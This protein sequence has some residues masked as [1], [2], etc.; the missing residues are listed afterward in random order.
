MKRLSSEEIEVA[1]TMR[2]NRVSWEKVARY[3]GVAEETVRRALDPDYRAA[4][5]EVAR[6]R[7]V[8][9]ERRASPHFADRKRLSAEDA[10]RALATVPADTRTIT[11]KVFGDPLP[12]RSALDRRAGA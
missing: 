5:N 6:R 7:Y 1:A 9:S 11:G 2:A 10:I 8:R 12:G 3:L 4:R